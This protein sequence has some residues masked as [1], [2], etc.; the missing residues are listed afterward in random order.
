MKRS[1]TNDI[2]ARADDFVRS[3]GYAVPPF[4]YWFPEEMKAR[5]FEIDGS[6]F[7]RPGW[8]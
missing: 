4:A 3:F 6:V 7:S 1:T 5:W 2:I 8:I